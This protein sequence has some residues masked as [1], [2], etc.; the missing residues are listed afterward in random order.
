MRLFLDEDS[1]G[2]L[3]VRLLRASGHD[4]QTVADVNLAGRTDAEV[5]GHAHREA[6]VLLT[7]NVKDFEAL[8]EANTEPHGILVEYQDRDPSK[9]L[10]AGDIVRAIANIEASGWDIAGQFV[11]INAWNY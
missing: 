1:Q 4:V 8:H 5:F 11:A 6:R 7:R 2:K 3:L 9:N 10:S